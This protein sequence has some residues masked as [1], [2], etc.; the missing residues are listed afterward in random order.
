[1]KKILP[2]VVALLV[3]SIIPTATMAQAMELKMNQSIEKD[4]TG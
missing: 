1:M 3:L 2:V 4:G